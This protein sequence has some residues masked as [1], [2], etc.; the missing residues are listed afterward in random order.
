MTVGLI[1]GGLAAI[2]LSK[3]GTWTGLASFSA[4]DWLQAV[5]AIGGVLR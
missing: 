4:G 2:P 1:G 3:P 5:A